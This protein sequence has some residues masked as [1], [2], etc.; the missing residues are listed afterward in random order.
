MGRPSRLLIALFVLLAALCAC[1]KGGEK[2]EAKRAPHQG[3]QYAGKLQ[4]RILPDVPTAAEDLQAVF[5]GEGNV[6]YRWEKNGAVL[7]DERGARLSRKLF[8]RGDRITLIATAGGEEGMASLTIENAPPQITSVSVTPENIC[9]GVDITAVP[10]GI[11]ADGDPIRYRYRW[12]INGEELPDD[13]AVL[14]GDK[15]KSG[16]RVSLKIT[17]S[18]DYG[19]GPEYAT[20]AFVIP[21]ALPYFV[22]TPPATFKDTTYVY[23]AQAKDPQGGSISYALVSAPPGMTIDGATGRIEWQVAGQSGS[24]AIEIEARNSKGQA[25][26]QKYN[27]A[28]TV[29]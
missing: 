23:D 21:D 26:R 18:D 6:T 15:F 5:R 28:V 8:S 17:P 19:D 9:R 11:D 20:Q 10:A 25:A 27:L 16:D 4:V 14:K 2:T 7:A 24:Y 13:T 22:S 3:V 29:P 1:S 12:F